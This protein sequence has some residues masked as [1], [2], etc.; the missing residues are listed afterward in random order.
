MIPAPKIAPARAGA[1]RGI[2]VASLSRLCGARVWGHESTQVLPQ[3][4]SQDVRPTLSREV[5]NPFCPSLSNLGL[6]TE[7]DCHPLSR[8]FRW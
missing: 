8:A 2:A 1:G 4:A 3:R 7:A 5:R 6:L